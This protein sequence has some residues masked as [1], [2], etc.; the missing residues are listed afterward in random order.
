ME[1]FKLQT[2]TAPTKNHSSKEKMKKIKSNYCF[3]H[4]NTWGWAD[5]SPV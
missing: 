4:L 3:G 5:I 1:K 2:K